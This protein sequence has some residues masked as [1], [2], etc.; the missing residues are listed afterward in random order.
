[1]N[2]ILTII[3]VLIAIVAPAATLALTVLTIL[4]VR[5]AAGVSP[6]EGQVCLRCGGLGPGG[7]GVF[8]YTESVGNA[9]ERAASRQVNPADTPILGSETHYICDQCARRFVWNEIVQGVILVLPYPL[10]LYVIIP[11]FAKGDIYANFL[12][13]TLLV[14]LSIAGTTTVFDLYRAS[15]KGSTPLADARDHVA[16]NERKPALGKKFSYYT[17]IGASHLRG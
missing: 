6:E 14:V 17:R 4:R 15:R 2:T 7:E 10:Y 9:R 13:E 5:K 3:H 12:I 16:I 8:H 11:I 1:M